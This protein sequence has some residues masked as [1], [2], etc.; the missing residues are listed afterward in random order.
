[1]SNKLFWTKSLAV[2]TVAQV[3]VKRNS[4]AK[5][6]RDI[7]AMQFFP[8]PDFKQLANKDSSKSD[9]LKLAFEQALNGDYDASGKGP[10]SP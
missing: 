9:L 3:E 2:P 6:I 1:M 4:F 10:H 8:V 5:Y 7:L